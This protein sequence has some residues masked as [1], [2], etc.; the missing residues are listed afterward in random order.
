M[1]EFDPMTAVGAA[2]ERKTER[3]REEEARFQAEQRAKLQLPNEIDIRAQ[4]GAR[5]V[6]AAQAALEEADDDMELTR[7]AEGYAL[8]GD[9]RKAIALTR[10]ETR[11]QEYVALIEAT[12]NSVP[13]TCPNM[14]NKV[15][16]KFIKDRILFDGQVRNIIACTICR[17]LTC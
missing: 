12:E 1:T 6:S 8:Q 4:L 11:R 17:K 14:V 7:L 16:T 2:L 3:E 9:Y 15:S 10:D 5:M 13:C